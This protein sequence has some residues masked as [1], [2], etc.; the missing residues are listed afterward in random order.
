MRLMEGVHCIENCLRTLWLLQSN[1]HLVYRL[2]RYVMSFDES[3][4][5]IYPITRY[6][7]IFEVVLGNIK[8]ITQS[9]FIKP[10]P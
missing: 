3:E 9:C 7:T 2:I 1:F 8:Q 5:V 10:E 4:N 6:L